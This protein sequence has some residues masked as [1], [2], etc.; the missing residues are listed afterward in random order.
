MPR[1]LR[2]SNQ[3][4]KPSK[5]P[6]PSVLILCEGA[7]TEPQYLNHVRRALGLSAVAV[8][9]PRGVPKTLVEIAVDRKKFGDHDAIWCVFDVDSHPNLSGAKQQAAAHGIK[10]AISNPC[11]ELWL[12]LHHVRYERPCTKEGIQREIRKHDADY[13]KNIDPARYWKKYPTARKNALELIARNQ[14]NNSIGQAPCTNFH[15]LIGELEKL[16]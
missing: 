4:K 7:N 15:E 13:N 3:R 6:R 5:N 10:L 14:R 1:L 8:E 11:V 12:V 2:K 16:I 9:G